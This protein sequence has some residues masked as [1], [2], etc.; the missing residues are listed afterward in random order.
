MI[1]NPHSNCSRQ[2]SHDSIFAGNDEEPTQEEWEDVLSQFPQKNLDEDVDEEDTESEGDQ[3]SE[4][5]IKEICS[6]ESHVEFDT[7]DG[8]GQSIGFRTSEST[9][10]KGKTEAEK[11]VQIASSDFI[12]TIPHKPKDTGT[13]IPNNPTVSNQKRQKLEDRRG[14]TTLT[15]QKRPFKPVTKKQSAPEKDTDKRVF[16]YSNRNAEGKIQAVKT[17]RKFNAGEVYKIEHSDYP[18]CKLVINSFSGKFAHGHV[19]QGLKSTYFLQ[20]SAEEKFKEF[21]DNFNFKPDDIVLYQDTIS[22]HVRRLGSKED[23]VPPVRVLIYN[24]ALPKKKDIFGQ[25]RHGFMISYRHGYSHSNDPDCIDDD[26]LEFHL[27]CANIDLD[28]I[29]AERKG[30]KL[31]RKIAN[32]S[33]KGDDAEY[34]DVEE[35]GKG[36]KGIVKYPPRDDDYFFTCLDVF[37]G[38]G[39]MS[40]GLLRAKFDVQFAVECCPIASTSFRL[41]HKNLKFLFE[42]KVQIWFDKIQQIH[43]KYGNKIDENDNNPYLQVLTVSHVHFSPVSLKSVYLCNH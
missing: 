27:D 23:F 42:E 14:Q 38:I 12:T 32:N 35:Q 15:Q 21:V 10:D 24:K 11:Q 20:I 18:D 9:A 5:G 28:G 3:E 7:N 22:M 17:W 30:G 19:Y 33:F 4:C 8:G 40:Q 26:D 13:N 41:N 37:A 29:L 25:E 43:K 6:Q 16:Y 1:S 34:L 36:D 31:D 39:G 2:V